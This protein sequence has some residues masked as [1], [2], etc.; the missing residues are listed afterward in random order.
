VINICLLSIKCILQIGA[1]AYDKILLYTSLTFVFP[2]IGNGMAA[3]LSDPITIVLHTLSQVFLLFS[4]FA[5]PT[6]YLLWKF[7]FLASMIRCLAHISPLHSPRQ[8]SKVP[9]LNGA[10]PRVSFVVQQVYIFRCWTEEDR[11]WNIALDCYSLERTAEGRSSS[12]WNWSGDSS[13]GLNHNRKKRTILICWGKLSREHALTATVMLLELS[14]PDA[15]SV[16]CNVT[17]SDSI[18]GHQC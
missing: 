16:L 11:Y 2:T 4:S 15:Y 3:N 9:N 1:K 13:K 10:I 18:N 8:S 5:F 17:R 12:N 14:V 7:S 6:S